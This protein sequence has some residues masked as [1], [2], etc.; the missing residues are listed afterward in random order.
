[1]KKPKSFLAFLAGGRARLSENAAGLA[2]NESGVESR[3][4]RETVVIDF[5]APWRGTFRCDR[6]PVHTHIHGCSSFSAATNCLFFFFFFFF[7]FFLR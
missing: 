5:L 1:M 2:T 6:R 3:E 7:F 4:S